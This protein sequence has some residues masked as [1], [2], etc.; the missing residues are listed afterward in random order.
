MKMIVHQTHA[1]IFS[2]LEHVISKQNVDK[3]KGETQR[4]PAIKA[5]L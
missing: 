3:D 5:Q 4:N 1:T 2:H